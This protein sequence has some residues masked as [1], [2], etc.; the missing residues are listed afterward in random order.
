MVAFRRREFFRIQRFRRR[1]DRR[2]GKFVFK[3]AYETAAEVTPRTVAV[4]E[5]FGLGVDEEQTFVVY[6]RA[7]LNYNYKSTENNG[8]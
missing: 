3:I 8:S 6:A 1:Y 4:S 7:T 5:A 2:A